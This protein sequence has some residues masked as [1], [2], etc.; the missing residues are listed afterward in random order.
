M[1]RA[2]PWRSSEAQQILERPSKT[3]LG[4][5]LANQKH[6]VADLET[7]GGGAP[8]GAA[9]E[10]THFHLEPLHPG[11]ASRIFLRTAQWRRGLL[12]FLKYLFVKR[13]NREHRR[14]AGEDVGAAGHFGRGRAGGEQRN[15]VGMR[16]RRFA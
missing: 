8:P 11:C 4:I 16:Q 1:W 3:S 7:S 6:L 13:L 10:Q 14:P 5:E 9:V 15:D 12:S 2:I